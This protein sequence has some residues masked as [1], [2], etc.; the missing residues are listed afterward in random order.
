MIKILTITAVEAYAQDIIG[1][2]EKNEVESFTYQEVIGYRDSTKDN[3]SDNWYAA[4]F[5]K[6]PS[7]LFYVFLQE[8]LVENITNAIN[9]FNDNNK[10]ISKIHWNLLSVERSNY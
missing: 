4:E 7:V 2:L 6:T 1:V 3:I 9:I 8:K 10:V 5:N